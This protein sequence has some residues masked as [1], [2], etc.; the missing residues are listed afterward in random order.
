METEEWKGDS[1]L[2]QVVLYYYMV[3][4][5]VKAEFVLKS[6]ADVKFAFFL[7]AQSLL[8]VFSAAQ[9]QIKEHDEKVLT[10]A[11][12]VILSVALQLDNQQELIEFRHIITKLNPDRA[13]LLQN[14][15]LASNFAIY[16]AFT[17]FVDPSHPFK[18]FC[19]TPQPLLDLTAYSSLLLTFS[20]AQA[21]QAILQILGTIEAMAIDPEDEKYLVLPVKVCRDRYR[22]RETIAR[23]AAS[24]LNKF[25]LTNL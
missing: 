6:L 16:R 24:C 15:S 3:Q 23:L 5:Q 8:S 2:N 19:L 13:N 25:K 18:Y 7:D 20:E 12:R 17:C 10:L 4:Q 21:D 9:L 22:H 11:N 1:P 14:L